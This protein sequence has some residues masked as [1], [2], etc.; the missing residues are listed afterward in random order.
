[1]PLDGLTVTMSER[2]GLSRAA[3][4]GCVNGGQDISSSSARPLRGRVL[5]LVGMA[6]VAVGITL[7]FP[8]WP[9]EAAYHDFADRRTILGVPNF[10]DVVSNVGFAVVGA[11]GVWFFVR[12]AAAAARGRPSRLGWADRCTFGA[13]FAGMFLTAFGSGRYHLAPDNA[14]LFWDRLGMSVA[15]MGFLAGMIAERVSRRAG[16]YLLAPLLL[17]GVAG[18]VY[19]RLTETQGAGDLRLYGL[20]HFFPLVAL[21]YM[22]LAFPARYLPARG[23]FVALGWYLLATVLEHLDAWVYGLGGVLSGHTL[24]HLAAAMGTYWV[25]RTIVRNSRPR[26]R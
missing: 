21:P 17:L 3:E 2:S 6:G 18:V 19:W 10:F 20:V 14:T 11:M 24:K 23:L 25:L 26:A 12:D 22:A 16:A 7:G 9:Q 15:F 4:C 5:V 1:M 8:R 13:M